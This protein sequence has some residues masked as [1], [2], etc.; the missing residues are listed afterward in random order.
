MLAPLL[1]GHPYHLNLITWPQ[2][3]DCSTP[4]AASQKGKLQG[5]LKV[6]VP[7]HRPFALSRRIDND[8]HR[9]A[10]LARLIYGDFAQ[11]PHPREAELQVGRT[12]LSRLR[13][14]SV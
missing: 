3:R 9:D 4:D 13:E 8:L 5:P 1:R 14:A 11:L 7:S 6:I 2:R 10:P 12:L